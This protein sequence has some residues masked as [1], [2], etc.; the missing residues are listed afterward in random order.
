MEV[1]ADGEDALLVDDS[2]GAIYIATWFGTA[3]EGMVRGYFDWFDG[4]VASHLRDRAPFVLITDALD[5]GRP[6]PS[7][8]KLIVKRTEAMPEFSSVNVGNYVVVGNALVRGALT[9]MQWISRRQWTSVNV[10]SMREALR[11]GL[12]DLRR[13]GAPTPSIDPASYERPKRPPRR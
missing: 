1:L 10:G 3:S 11:R 9:A 13:A 8:R 12:D 7:A 4:V 2:H 6:S 5:A